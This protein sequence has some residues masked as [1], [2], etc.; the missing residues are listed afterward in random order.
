VAVNADGDEA[1]RCACSTPGVT[2]VTNN[3]RVK[4]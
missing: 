1:Q 2:K 4:S 3:L